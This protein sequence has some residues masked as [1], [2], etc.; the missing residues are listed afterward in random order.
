MIKDR[1]NGVQTFYVSTNGDDSI[2]NGTLLNPYKTIE[3]AKEAVKLLEKKVPIEVVFLGGTYEVKNTI[4]FG[5]E[6]SGT[7]E[8]PICYKA[9]AGEQV[10]F[11]G[12]LRLDVSAFEPVNE[13]IK[14]RLYDRVKEKVVQMDLKKQGVPEALAHF[15]EFGNT[16]AIGR[17]LKPLIFTLNG[18]RQSIAR[19]PNS[20]YNTIMACKPGGTIRLDNEDNAGTIYYTECNPARWTKA[21]N[22]YIEGFLGTFWHSEWA[23][24]KNIDIDNAAINMCYHTMYGIA[25][26]HRWAAVNLLEE[27]D[28]PGEWYI[29]PDSM[30]LYYYPPYELMDNDI[31]E[32]AALRNNILSI[33]GAEYLSFE[34]IE[35]TMT[36]NDPTVPDANDTGGNGIYIGQKAKNILIKNCI[37]SHIGMHGISIDAT[38]V[39]IDGCVI[40]DIGFSG[41]NVGNCGD[42]KTLTPSNVVIKNCDIS[43]VSRDSGLNAIAG[44]KLQNGSVDVTVMNNLIHNCINSAIRYEGNGHHIC[45]N[46]FYN[47]VTKTA[48]AGA[49]YAGRSWGEYGTSVD[50]NFFHDIGSRNNLSRY[51]VS[52][53]FWDD[54]Q[55]GGEFSHNISVVNNYVK[56][57][58][59]KIG[60]G[61]DNV[62]RGNTMV[63]SAE[64]IIGEDRSTSRKIDWPIF[65]TL[66]LKLSTVPY[67]SPEWQIKYPQMGTLLS[68]IESNDG[69]L[70]LEN[71][72]TDNLSVDCGTSRIAKTMKESSVYANNV[73][74]NEE[75]D[76]FVAPEQLDYRVKKAAKKKYKISDAVLDEDFDLDRIGIANGYHLNRAGMD[77]IVTYPEDNTIIERKDICLAWS[78]SQLADMYRYVVATDPEFKDIV[79]EDTT[80]EHAVVL[81]GL[82]LGTAYY[83]K[84]IAQNTSRRYRCEVQAS[85]GSRCFTTAKTETL[86]MAQL[87]YAINSA[88][89]MM[90]SIVEGDNAEEYRQGTKEALKREIDKAEAFLGL[91]YGVQ[92]EINSVTFALKDSLNRVGAMVNQG[93]TTLNMTASSEWYANRDAVS[94]TPMNGSVRV[95]VSYDTELSLVKELSN[96]NVVCFRVQIGT[97]DNKGV[98]I[99]LRATNKR[100]PLYSQDVHHILINT[101]EIVLRR[102]NRVC[103]VISNKGKIE[104]GEWYEV[105]FG[106]ITTQNGVH[107]IFKVNGETL[108]DYLDKS[109]SQ[110]KPGMF[111]VFTYN[112]NV[113]E[114]ADAENVPQGLYRMS[115]QILSELEQ[116][117]EDGKV[118]D[119]DA[120]EY[121]E[122]GTWSD[123]GVLRGENGSKVRT[124][125][126]STSSAKWILEAGKKGNGK[127]YRVFYYHIP[128]AEGDPNVTIRISGYMGE[129]ETQVDMSKGKMGYVEIGT[130]LFLSADYV[131]RVSVEFTGSGSGN[132]N[133]SNVKFEVADEKKY[134]NML[135]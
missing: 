56:T 31:F 6:D 89:T 110:N 99:G 58:S 35:F 30:M 60:G 88:Y 135:K 42:R 120:N 14:E 4:V 63:S 16:S 95:E 131:G 50:Y 62:V 44:I 75:N 10:V 134:S 74:I 113:I 9:K 49:I 57:S 41:I 43:N 45:Y 53:I 73:F 52:S 130:F 84:V 96:Y 107:I 124:A 116:R 79:A 76:I 111:A 70:K 65:A 85:N 102:R 129:Y 20:G 51:P 104:A 7:K 133:V 109:D 21:A 17:K 32:V 24:V 22:M 121:I 132:V 33:L 54:F 3:A 93:Y 2:A 69:V 27:I 100:V 118:L 115:P 103:A 91:Q 29:E 61:I 38:D 77:F 108:F 39:I 67:T 55:A 97:I 28:I 90:N 125:Q 34:G 128:S 105:Q 101:D 126:N 78:R 26:N 87:K 36:A 112:D 59:V 66:D 81:D 47:V 106:A 119:V 68:R 37:L 15:T 11:S 23:K 122:K 25:E 40:Y 98:L 127:L 72:I 123:N 64:D 71:I 48:D 80:I 114:I 83:W 18:S 8:A 12:A 117:E 94:L 13:E 5:I 19:W 82:E 86:D 92:N 46:E 1:K